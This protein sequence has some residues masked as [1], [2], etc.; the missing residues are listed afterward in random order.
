LLGNKELINGKKDIIVYHNF[1]SAEECNELIT[2]FNSLP[3][4]WRPICFYG[5]YGMH[6]V[7]P[8]EFNHNTSITAEKINVLKQK[9]I[10]AATDSSGMQT[11]L[12]SIHAQKWDVGA[13]ANDHSDNSDLEGK[14]MGWSDNKFATILYL[15]DNYEGGTIN[16]RDHGISLKLAPGDLLTF[17][18][19]M[20]NIHSVSEIT[21]GTRYTIVTF[22]DYYSSWYSELELQELERKIMKERIHQYQLKQRWK[23]GEAHPILE[24][25]YVGLDDSSKL[26]KGFSDSLTSADIK[27]N[28][29]KN[30]ERAIKEG[31]VPQGII[32]DMILSEDD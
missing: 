12:N 23:L 18:G 20:E 8:L 1:I 11:K 4:E 9:M 5:S 27:S 28:A 3:E 22:Q 16:F 6:I 24:D 17:P 29:R 10:D 7:A 32:V 31:R 19:G 25:P 15:N 21:G 2:F 26:P 13:Y 14:D 30:Q